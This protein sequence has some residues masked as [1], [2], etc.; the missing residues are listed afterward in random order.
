VTV[1][2][3]LHNVG[4]FIESANLNK[5]PPQIKNEKSIYQSIDGWGISYGNCIFEKNS[6]DA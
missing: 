1:K 3:K 2:S 5:L 6:I 4:I